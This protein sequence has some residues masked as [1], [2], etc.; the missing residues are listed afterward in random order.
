MPHLPPAEEVFLFAAAAGTE[1]EK[2]TDPDHTEQIDDKDDQFSC[3]AHGKPP[4]SSFESCIQ[5]KII[6]MM[7]RLRKDSF[8]LFLFIMLKQKTAF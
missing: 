6:S 4:L 7:M 5:G 1:E 2:Y 3:V 8:V